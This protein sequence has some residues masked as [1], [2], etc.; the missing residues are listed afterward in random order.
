[1]E[2]NP[3]TQAYQTQ[4]P[5]MRNHTQYIYRIS[6]PISRTLLS[7]IWLLQQINKNLPMMHTLLFELLTLEIMSG[8]LFQQL[9]IGPTMER[10]LDHQVSQVNVEITDGRQS[11]INRVQRRVQAPPQELQNNNTSSNPQNT[12]TQWDQPLIDHMYIPL[13]NQAPQRC[14][15]QQR[16]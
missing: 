1:M 14:Y 8:C 7:P 4:Q 13:L 16:R 2:G 3:S 9:E 6:L 15:P 11:H 5:L 10:E 12:A